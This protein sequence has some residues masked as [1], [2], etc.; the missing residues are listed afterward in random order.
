[1]PPCTFL[2]VINVT[3][4][5]FKVVTGA[6]NYI[7]QIGLLRI[8]AHARFVFVQLKIKGVQISKDEGTVRVKFDCRGYGML[9]MGLEYLPKKLYKRENMSALAP[10]WLDAISTYHVDKDGKIFRHI[11]DNKEEDKGDPVK[12][13]VDTIKEKVLKLREKAPVASPAL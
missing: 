6:I 13:T 11:L 1:M 4:Y 3:Q 9:R 7:K 10:V 12:S 8:Y 2:I 5:A